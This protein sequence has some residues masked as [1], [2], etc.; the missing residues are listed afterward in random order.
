MAIFLIRHGETASNA[1]RIVQT[2]DTPLSR[3]GI[4]Q[5][6][7]LGR[8]LARS[9]ATRILS[10][11]L[12]RALMTA[13]A[14]NEA[15]GAPIS[16]DPGLQERN[17]G[18]LRGRAYADLGLNMFAPDYLPPG[19][20]GWDEFHARVDAVWQRVLAAVRQIEGNLLVVTHGLV[21]YSLA[22]RQL[23]LPAGVAAPERWENTS[24]TIVASEPPWR[25]SV[26]NCTDHLDEETGADPSSSSSL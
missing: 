4:A 1:A 7:R 17:F 23:Q 26:L 16:T 18:D 10:S 20:E 19:G 22:L 12:T 15:T 14:L 13:T 5:A 6:D 9:G 2:P 21:C 3:R 8:R 11:D 25:V 24:V